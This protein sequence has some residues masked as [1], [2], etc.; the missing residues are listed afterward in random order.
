V[1]K[2]LQAFDTAGRCST[3]L[4]PRNEIKYLF[5]KS[6]LNVRKGNL[7]EAMR[8]AKEAVGKCESNR[9]MLGIDEAH[10][11]ER[12]TNIEFIRKKSAASQ[13]HQAH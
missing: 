8:S 9:D 6:D 7:V 3:N 13:A 10:A 12:V 2:I 11:C 5:A 1:E 4:V